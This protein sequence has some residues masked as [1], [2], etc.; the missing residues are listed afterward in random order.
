MHSDY[1]S[2]VV[3]CEIPDTHLALGA[4]PWDEAQGG[5]LA[6]ILELAR[7]P[8]VRAETQDHK[9]DPTPQTQ[10]QQA[11]QDGCSSRACTRSLLGRQW[12][13]AAILNSLSS[14]R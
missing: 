11:D 10:D 4:E 12:P 5:N 3:G 14:A 6:D 7:V 9:A 8:H 1:E 13:R 2:P